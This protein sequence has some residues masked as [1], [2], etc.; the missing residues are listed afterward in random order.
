MQF[1]YGY[2][3]RVFEILKKLSGGFSHTEHLKKAENVND[4]FLPVKY[5][6]S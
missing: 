3:D 1:F 4:Q 5:V 6:F 2:S